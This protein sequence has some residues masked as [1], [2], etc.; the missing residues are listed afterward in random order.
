MWV[1]LAV[2]LGEEYNQ[3]LDVLSVL[4]MLLGPHCRK[5]REPRDQALLRPC[6]ILRSESEYE[7]K[8]FDHKEIFGIRNI[9][10]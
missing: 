6:C 9:R 3:N 7:L 5:R 1:E 2:I 8:E 4:K 10:A